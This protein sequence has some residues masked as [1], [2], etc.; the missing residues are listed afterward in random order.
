MEI[1]HF[2]TKA[3][4]IYHFKTNDVPESRCRCSPAQF[5]MFLSVEA[6]AQG[7]LRAAPGHRGAGTQH[8]IGRGRVSRHHGQDGH[9]H[10]CQVPEVR[11]LSFSKPI[12]SVVSLCLFPFSLALVISSFCRLRWVLMMGGSS[13]SRSSAP[14]QSLLEDFNYSGPRWA[15]LVVKLNFI[16]VLWF[17]FFS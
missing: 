15:P 16:K 8:P 2:R 12:K 14:R 7:A 9:T 6:A 11:L 3:N 17:S 5:S 13:T 1:K 4:N 10:H